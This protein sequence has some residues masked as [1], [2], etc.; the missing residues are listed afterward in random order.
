MIFQSHSLIAA[1][2]LAVLAISPTL[3][4]TPTYSTPFR[5]QSKGIAVA[6]PWVFQD[7]TDTSRDTALK[8]ASEIL[9]KANYAPIS[10]DAAKSAWGNLP[11]PRFDKLPSKATLQKFG[12]ATNAR[13]VLY[14]SVSWHT[15]SIWVN[16]G[17]KTVST[18]TVSAYVY[19]VGSGKVVYRKA[20]VEGRSDEKENAYKIAAD[21]LVTPLVTVVSGGPKTPQE[22]RAVQIGLGRALHDWVQKSR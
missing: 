21:I 1:P 11:E 19:D 14:G 13:V 4:A 5:L 12:R 7:G 17:P 2:L 3:P 15:R 18:A 9:Q 20:G 6:Y 16:T 8:T 22:Q 10:T